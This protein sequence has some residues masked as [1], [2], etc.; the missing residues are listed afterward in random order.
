MMPWEGVVK[1]GVRHHA[2]EDPGRRECLEGED[3][4]TTRMGS[5]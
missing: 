2:K 4:K 3:S 1:S 5:R